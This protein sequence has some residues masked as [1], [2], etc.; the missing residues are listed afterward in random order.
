[1]IIFKIIMKIQFLPNN[2]NYR[3]KYI[4]KQWLIIEIITSFIIM[5]SFVDTR[6]P[7]W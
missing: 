6:L 1:M 3:I 2:S 5:Q 4:S 7:Y